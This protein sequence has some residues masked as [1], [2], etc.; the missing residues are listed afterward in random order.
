MQFG[1]AEIKTKY[2]YLNCYILCSLWYYYH[3]RKCLF[4]F[5]LVPEIEATLVHGGGWASSFLNLI[6]A[7]SPGWVSLPRLASPPSHPSHDCQPLPS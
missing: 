1:G 4:A 7:G 2:A 6:T 5:Y 3:C